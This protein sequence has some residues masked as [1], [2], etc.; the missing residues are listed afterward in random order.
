M[1]KAVMVHGEAV[2]EAWIRRS[3]QGSVHFPVFDFLANVNKGRWKGADSRIN[4]LKG[5]SAA[6]AELCP[7]QHAETGGRD[8]H[9]PNE[10]DHANV[11]CC[12]LRISCDCRD[13]NAS[14]FT[15]VKTFH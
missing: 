3:M 1:G 12:D 9:E 4:A 13:E 11:A 10:K 2:I 15:N 6:R 8:H 5:P 14:L 7:Q